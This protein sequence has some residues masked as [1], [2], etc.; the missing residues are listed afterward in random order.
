MGLAFVRTLAGIL[1]YAGLSLLVLVRVRSKGIRVGVMQA[2]LMWG[3]LI[4]V[5]TE[6]LSAFR[7]LR[8]AP[9]LAFW[10]AALVGLGVWLWRARLGKL[11]ALLLRLSALARAHKVQTLAT[12]VVLAVTLLIALVA[13]PNNWDSMTT[14]MNRV[15]NWKQNG[16]VGHYPVYYEQQLA[17]PPLA[18]FIIL[19]SQVLADGDRFANTLQWASLVGA[20]FA[21]AS[22]TRQLGGSDKAMAFSLLFAGTIPMAILQASSTQSDL[23]VSLWLTIFVACLLENMRTPTAKGYAWEGLAL[24]LATLTKVTAYIAAFPFALWQIAHAL[25]RERLRAIPHGALVVVLLLGVNSAFLGRNLETFG[26]PITSSRSLARN[27]NERFGLDVTISNLIRN[28][29]LH[30]STFKEAD[31]ALYKAIEGIHELAGWNVDDPATSLLRFGFN[32]FSTHEDTAGNAL[33]FLLI[34]GTIPLVL[35][36]ARSRKNHRMIL[37]VATILAGG[38]FFCSYLKWSPWKQRLHLP[39]FLLFSPAVA[40]IAADSRKSWLPV[41]LSGILA[42][43]CAP[44]LLWNASRPLLALPGLT[45]GPSIL[46]A[47][48]TDQYFINRKHLQRQYEAAL[49]L[50]SRIGCEHLAY[51]RARNGW[52]YPLRVLADQQAGGLVISKPL[53][54]YVPEDLRQAQ[55]DA[56]M[57][58]GAAQKAIPRNPA[59]GR[60]V[61]K[62]PFIRIYLPRT[63]QAETA[64]RTQSPVAM[65]ADE[66]LRARAPLLGRQRPSSRLYRT[67][68][69]QN[70][71]LTDKSDGQ[72]ISGR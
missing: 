63:A 24:A 70:R 22:I 17:A 30:L 45:R 9:V 29:S 8:F 20:L 10:I 33:H 27:K 61:F 6:A 60:L 43:G 51:V 3:C 26:H 18:G 32:G 65:S 48:R 57:Y 21:V 11:R 42:L 62:S 72:Y 19:H 12:A 59:L 25:R 23:V 67:R 5:S 35:C 71:P 31:K 58:M 55:F 54:H 40:I 68:Q 49:R 4:V 16:H 66:A 52:E 53:A 44:W 64:T 37:Y 47:P 1:P 39:W 38:V 28:G 2:F 69:P 41:L 14:Y 50:L 56:W 15:A 7:M 13:P 34:L 46:S 36:L